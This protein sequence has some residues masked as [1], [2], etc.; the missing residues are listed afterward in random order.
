VEKAAVRG[1]LWLTAAR[2][3]QAL[4]HFGGIFLLARLYLGKEELGLAGLVLAVQGLLSAGA[5]L[6]MGVLNVQRASIDDRRAA[7]LAALGGAGC[8][9][10]L[11]LL[12]EPVAELL[13]DP[14]GL[15]PLLRAGSLALLL[16]GFVAT[17]RARIARELSFGTL[18]GVDVAVALV[19]AGAR[20]GFAA[21][22]HGAWA[23]VLGDLLA[24]CVG[25]ALV[26][27]FAPGMRRAPGGPLLPDGL[28]IVGTRAADSAFA[29]ADRFL[30]GRSLGTA[31]LGLYGFAWQHAMV[32]VGQ[33]TPVAE[34]V[35]LPVLSRLQGDRTALA[36]TYLALTRVFALAVVPFA[37]LLWAL[38]P[39]LVATLYPDRWLDAVPIMRALCIA[40]AAAG[41]NSHPGLVWI[42]V[43]K[44]G[45]R[46]RWSAVNL[47]ALLAVIAA[48]LPYGATGVAYALAARS[49]LATVAAQVITQRVAGVPHRAYVAALLPALAVAAVIVLV[50]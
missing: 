50:S 11:L 1:A 43:G 26:W 36:K 24:A 47:V 5:D 10:L 20:V 34:Q 12:A 3:V 45:L 38:A 42:A 49:L 39:W 2:G 48:G 44:I 18:A 19:A 29:Q 25:A 32:L 28:R 23:I 8:C 15:V 4:A 9:A 22:G 14:P 27:L 46:A 33:L 17:A 13:G 37:A 21:H 31:V 16:A 40:A 41:L 6:G 30:I 7:R 35:A